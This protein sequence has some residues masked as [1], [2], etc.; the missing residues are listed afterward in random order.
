[1]IPHG[2][3]KVNVSAQPSKGAGICTSGGAKG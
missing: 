2:E 3:S 1:L